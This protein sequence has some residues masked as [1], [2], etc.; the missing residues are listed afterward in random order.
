MYVKIRT[1]E[2]ELPQVEAFYLD[3]EVSYKV[4]ELPTELVD[5]LLSM[6]NA[7][8]KSKDEPYMIPSDRLLTGKVAREMFKI[9]D[10]E[11]NPVE[12]KPLD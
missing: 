11:L 7:L 5:V 2:Y 9:L 12:L 1:D 3:E 10:K 6:Y 8:W 4:Y